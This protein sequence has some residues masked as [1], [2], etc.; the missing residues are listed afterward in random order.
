MNLV[1]LKPRVHR[2][3]CNMDTSKL[4]SEQLKKERTKVQNQMI[5]AA[6]K[7]KLNILKNSVENK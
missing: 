5:Y 6:Q 7:N 2:Y 3:Y 1:E 4:N